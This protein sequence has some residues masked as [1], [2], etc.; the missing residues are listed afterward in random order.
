MDIVCVLMSSDQYQEAMLF[1]GCLPLLFDSATVIIPFI[2]III[3]TSAIG[4][5]YKLRTQRLDEL[6]ELGLCG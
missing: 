1:L 4:K 3:I 5:I 6:D 2:I